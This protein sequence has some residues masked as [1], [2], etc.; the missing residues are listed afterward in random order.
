MVTR[1]CFFQNPK[2]AAKQSAN[3]AAF[4][5]GRGAKGLRAIT[6]TGT[7]PCRFEK[8]VYQ[9]GDK[10]LPLG[11]LSVS[12]QGK[13][14]PA[15]TPL[16]DADGEIVGLIL[17]PASGNT[18]Y[19][20]PCQAVHRVLHDIVAHRKLVRGWMGI[21]LSTSSQVPRITGVIPGSPAATAGLRENDILTRAGSYTT[22]RYPDA[23]NAL[24]Y[25]V[26]GKPTSLEVL[27]DNKRIECKITP[28]AK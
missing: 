11:L 24:F 1:L 9:V 25:S 10:I 13:F 5:D 19:A 27:R 17:Q 3:W 21:A 12:F 14:P 20:I 23:V 28:I 7:S 8:W 16:V 18:G 26:P 6:D 2:P 22:E 4:F 15:G